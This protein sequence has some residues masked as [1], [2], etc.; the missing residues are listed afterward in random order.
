M[1]RDLLLTD[2]SHRYIGELKRVL[3]EFPHE[4]F[5]RL[6]EVLLAAYRESKH[7]FVMGNGGSAATA[8]HWVCDINKGC[9]VDKNVKFKMMSL[10]DSVSTML[11]YANDVCFEDIFVEQ[12]KNFFVPGDVVIGLSGSGNSPNVL[13]AIDFAN[14]NRGVTVGLCGFTG[15]L[16]LQKVHIPVWA[17]IYDMQ[18]A[19]DF[20][21]IVA[22]MA[23]Q[24]LSHEVDKLHTISESRNLV[25]GL[26]RSRGI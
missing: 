7:I 4:Q 23:M 1:E 9:S 14:A 22:H 8:S 17:P 10:N 2:F 26:V 13:K 20:H 6:I 19:E 18:R 21:L 15:G 12:L 5:N 16:L 24:R 3:D 11:A 25:E